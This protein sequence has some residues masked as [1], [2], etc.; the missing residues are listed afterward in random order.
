MSLWRR[1]EKLHLRLGYWQAAAGVQ[2]RQD[3]ALF[4]GLLHYLCSAGGL[5]LFYKGVILD[6]LMV[7]FYP[8]NLLG[9]IDVS[10]LT[11]LSKQKWSKITHEMSQ[12][13]LFR[14]SLRSFS[15]GCCI[16]GHIQ[17]A[18]VLEVARTV[19]SFSLWSSDHRSAL[20]PERRLIIYY[21]KTHFCYFKSIDK[22]VFLFTKSQLDLTGEK[23]SSNEM[24]TLGILIQIK[25]YLKSLRFGDALKL[26]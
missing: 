9:I 17:K 19:R 16:I 6:G 24:K 26:T 22:R 23:V 3:I 10:K 11:L 4:K 12:L 18:E 21:F 13:L 25:V 8:H 1:F 5:M 2:R 14:D 15:I 7:F 20:V